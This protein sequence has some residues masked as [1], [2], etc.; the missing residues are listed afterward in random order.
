MAPIEY[1]AA[2]M[3]INGMVL[4]LGQTLGPVFMGLTFTVWGIQGAFLAGAG[5]SVAAFVLLL[6]YD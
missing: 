5:F 3:S 2:F 1:R 6:I 4:R